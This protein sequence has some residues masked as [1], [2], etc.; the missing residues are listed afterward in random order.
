MRNYLKI[1]LIILPFLVLNCSKTDKENNSIDSQTIENSQIT[2]NKYKQLYNSIYIRLALQKSLGQ[3]A[4]ALFIKDIEIIKDLKLYSEVS[5]IA[6]D[7]YRYNDVNIIARQWSKIDPTSSHPFELGFRASLELKDFTQAEY[8]LKKYLYIEQPKNK[9]DYSKLFFSLLE[10]KNR[11]NVINFFDNYI[12]RQNNRELIISY[13]EL[14]Y[15]YNKSIQVIKYIDNIGSFNERNLIRLYASSNVLIN[16]L[17]I[18]KNTLLKFLKNKTLP[19]RQVQL[20]LLQV[21]L[22]LND[23]ELAENLIIKMLDNT[24]G[25]IS[26]I[27]NVS[28]I[29]YENNYYDLS[30]KYLSS[31]VENSD[32]I[33]FLRGMLDLKSGNYNESIA[34]FDKISDYNYKILSIFNKV[35]ALSEISGNEYAINYLD[36]AQDKFDSYNDRLRF[37]LQKIYLL[38]QENKFEEIIDICTKHLINEKHN[39]EI[40]YSRAMAY[41]AL[42]NIPKME[43]DLKGILIIDEKNTNTLNALGYSLTIHTQRYDE[44]YSLILQAYQNDPGNAAILDSMAWGYYKK[45]DYKKALLF[46]EIAYKK[47]RDP[48]IIEH[49]CKI[50]E[51]NK[52]YDKLKKIISFVIENYS[53]KKDLIEKLKILN[54][55]IRI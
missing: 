3:E 21:Y 9:R 36:S 2:G 22:S 29:L 17:E 44:A 50:L 13:I 48:E 5:K 10:N 31:L 25:D 34:H 28:R 1:L 16:E 53:D 8:Y 7:S 11:L 49:F 45:G 40:L 32:R 4:L 27:Y 46:S 43:S 23:T 55:E 18:A 41:E 15:S 20:E 30:E 38:R 19:D 14:L 42:G 33:I 54:N 39:I 26:L 24:S 35:T 12:K 47:D 6:L 37:L 51:K 52:M